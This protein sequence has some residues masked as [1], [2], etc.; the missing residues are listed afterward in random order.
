MS[1]N[2]LVALVRKR[3]KN[4]YILNEE[5]WKQLQLLDELKSK[6]FVIKQGPIVEV[7]KFNTKVAIQQVFDEINQ[8]I[9]E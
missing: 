7:A 8:K 3:H 5:I 9:K 6:F 2:D 1:C 4:Q